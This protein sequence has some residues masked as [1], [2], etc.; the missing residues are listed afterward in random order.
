MFI[1]IHNSV[2]RRPPLAVILAV[3]LAALAIVPLHFVFANE[4][5]EK[6]VVSFF[7]YIAILLIKMF[8]FLL[9]WAVKLIILVAQHNVFINSRAVSVGWV[10]VRDV[11][12]MFFIIILLVIA[13]GTIL[14]SQ[15][16]TYKNTIV[17]MIIMVIVVN[18]SK[19]ICGFFIDAS[20][21]VMGAFVDAVK[22]NAEA[23]LISGFGIT[24]MLRFA[25]PN[26]ETTAEIKLIDT[27]VSIYLAVFMFIIATIVSVVIVVILLGRIIALWILIILSPIAFVADILPVTQKYAGQWWQAFTK[28]L[29]V[30]PVLMFFFWL[31][32][33][34]MSDPTAPPINLVGFDPVSVSIQGGS[35]AKNVAAAASAISTPQ[36]MFDYMVAIGLLFATLQMAQSMGVAGGS[37]AGKAHQMSQGML[38][39]APKAAGKLAVGGALLADRKWGF[40]LQY[41]PE[42]FKH[43][44]EDRK[45]KQRTKAEER[46]MNYVRKAFGVEIF[47]DKDVR[48][49]EEA[50][51]MK[52]A[53]KETIAKVRAAKNAEDVDAI[54]LSDAETGDGVNKDDLKGFHE[55]VQKAKT[56]QVKEGQ[57][58]RMGKL[59]M[60][61][62]FLSNTDDFMEDFGMFSQLKSGSK[63]WA[64]IK[65]GIDP[66]KETE[67]D[68][69][70]SSA[71]QKAREESP[72]YVDSETHREETEKIEAARGGLKD[73]QGAKVSG[74]FS[75]TEYAAGI[76]VQ[77]MATYDREMT[78]IKRGIAEAKQ[79]NEDEKVRK[80][81][82]DRL[83]LELDQKRIKD[84]LEPYMTVLE[85]REEKLKVRNKQQDIVDDEDATPEERASARGR[86]KAIDGEIKAIDEEIKKFRTVEL[87]IGKSDSFYNA[88]KFEDLFDEALA[89][90]E[91]DMKTDEKEYARRRKASTV[92]KAREENEGVKAHLDHLEEER[93]EHFVQMERMKAPSFFESEARKRQ[94]EMEV[95]KNVNTD[96][97]TEIASVMREALEKKDTAK[98]NGLFRKATADANGNEILDYF[99]FS[100]NARGM[101]EFKKKI[102][103]GHLGMNENESGSLLNDIG[104]IAERVN[105]W[106]MA[107]NHRVNQFGLYEATPDD[108]RFQEL[109]AEMSKMNTADLVQKGNRLAYGGEHPRYNSNSRRWERDFMF[110]EHGLS[111]IAFNFPEIVQTIERR[112]LNKNAATKFMSR[113]AERQLRRLRDFE[114]I[115]KAPYA[116]FYNLLRAHSGRG[117]GFELGGGYD[118]YH[119]IVRY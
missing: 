98:F 96:N 106:G 10:V 52:G 21:V 36:R 63:F 100:S 79:G 55:L 3:A 45:K 78:E 5:L 38:S 7:G 70:L 30:G 40:G 117:R 65:G 84:L 116:K 41:M 90:A 80:L 57:N 26:Q 93:R 71:L 99:G 4:D 20:N 6:A 64:L 115:P 8:G 19:T 101:N 112:P 37:L 114:F 77:V 81:T 107:R 51:R 102:L 50:L 88:K 69:A 32:L 23:H 66:A 13:I 94:L 92:K 73:A 72:I 113:D 91:S 105:H 95:T 49:A 34:V 11:M 74:A 67:R 14:R 15:R 48:E 68:H 61:R 47:G 60:L 46:G 16:F 75:N 82:E 29:I 25:D 42:K 33:I 110:D 17:K 58:V 54:D 31:S 59:G 86:I 35:S 111:A 85:K 44:M 18:F 22:G 27:L 28:Y 119:H 56:G 118:Q 39:W 104:Y 62:M 1:R 43:V 109:V 89:T 9:S 53:S 103:M 87:K 76:L 2:W 97:W 12:N 24:D 108:D 83:E